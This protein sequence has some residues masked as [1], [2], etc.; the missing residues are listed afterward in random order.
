[1]A[2]EVK[3]DVVEKEPAASADAGG[4]DKGVE[5]GSDAGSDAGASEKPEAA[6]KPAAPA[7]KPKTSVLDDDDEIDDG[8]KGDESAKPDAKADDKPEGEKEPAANGGQW[9]EEWAGGN[10]K[11]LSWLKRYA[12]PKAAAAAGFAAVQKIRSGDYKQAELADDATPEEKKAYYEERGIPVEAKDYDIPKVPGHTWTEA[13]T[14]V[15]NGFKDVAHALMLPQAAMNGLTEWFARTIDAQKQAAQ[16]ALLARDSTDKEALSDALR[17]EI[18]NAEYKPTI[19]LMKRLI[20]DPDVM[21][22]GLGTE[23]LGARTADGRRLINNPAFA[24]LLIQMSRDTYGDGGFITGDARAK[25]DSRKS[26]IE[27][28][29]NTNIEQYFAEGLDKE[30]LQILEREEKTSSRGRAA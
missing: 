2:D 11:L 7:A 16:D 4:A 23:L 29:K 21:P 25:H 24:K 22:D 13:D 8:G 1:M 27:R 6:A 17:T 3:A 15:L 26:E 10:D 19:A 30:Y 28:I 12:S 9:R 5:S 14:P 18:G 20:E